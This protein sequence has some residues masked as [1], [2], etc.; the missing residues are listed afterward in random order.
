MMTVRNTNDHRIDQCRRRQDKQP[1]HLPSAQS[2]GGGSRAGGPRPVDGPSAALLA[3][4]EILSLPYVHLS[5]FPICLVS[6]FRQ[7]YQHFSYCV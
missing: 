7:I 2:S 3:G 6:D 5:N 1:G 4:R